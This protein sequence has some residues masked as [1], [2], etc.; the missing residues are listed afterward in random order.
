MASGS[1]TYLLLRNGYSIRQVE[2]Q[3]RGF[4]SKYMAS[5]I[6]EFLGIDLPEFLRKGNRIGFGFQPITSIHLYS[7][8]DD[9][10]EANGDIKYVYIFSAIALFILLL[11]CINFMNLS[12]AGSAGRSKEV[13]IRKV[14]GPFRSS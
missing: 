11:A 2:A 12:T 1:Y 10:L 6:K 9:E 7:D 5:E 14:L 8:L 3:S 4:L 13:G